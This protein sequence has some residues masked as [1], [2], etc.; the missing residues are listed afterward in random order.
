MNPPPPS[1]RTVPPVFRCIGRWVTLVQLVGYTTALIYVWQTTRLVPAGIVAHYRGSEAVEGAMQFPKSFSEMLSITH[2][3]LLAMLVIFV[4]S[5]ASLALCER[6][7][8]GRKRFLI[9]EPF[10]ALLISFSAMWLM[11]YA[12]PRFSILLALSST[13]MAVTFYLQSALVLRELGL[14]E[15]PRQRGER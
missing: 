9:I 15:V 5:G 4:L 8:E 2:T 6:V 1:W 14:R 12:H 7:T 13:I 11:R 10:V 3:H